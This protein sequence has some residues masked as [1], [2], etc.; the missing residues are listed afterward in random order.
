[1]IALKVFSRSRPISLSERV[2]VLENMGFRVVDERTYRIEPAQMAPVWFH[3]MELES[4]SAQ[5][6]DLSA[7]EGRLQACFLVVM[8]GASSDE[9][10]KAPGGSARAGRGGGALGPGGGGAFCARPHSLFPGFF[11]SG[12]C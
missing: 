12:H 8:A 4:A 5:P 1:R 3:D 9:G 7:S 10:Y 11:L 6:V 2:P